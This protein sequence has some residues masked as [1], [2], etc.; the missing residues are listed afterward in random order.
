MSYNALTMPVLADQSSVPRLATLPPLSMLDASARSVRLPPPV[1]LSVVFGAIIRLRYAASVSDAPPCQLT[2]DATFRSPLWPFAPV[3][4]TLT[5]V[6]AFRL[7]SNVPPA[8]GSIGQLGAATFHRPASTVGRPIPTAPNDNC[9]PVVST[10][11][12]RPSALVAS[13]GPRKLTLPCSATS[14]T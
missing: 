6:P 7:R 13:M 1:F 2:L 5:A 10:V 4:S 8:A 14:H 12:P 3:V 9:A 11:P